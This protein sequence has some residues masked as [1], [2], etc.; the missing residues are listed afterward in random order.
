[1]PDVPYPSLA[2]FAATWSER[3]E[4]DEAPSWLHPAASPL[5]FVE[6]VRLKHELE[7]LI[8]TV[9]AVQRGDWLQD[10]VWV[11]P[12]AMGA[13]YRDL[14]ECSRT[15]GI[16]VPPAVVSGSAPSRQGVFGTDARAFLHLSSFFLA[17]AAPAERKFVIGR[18][19]GHVAAHQVTWVTS[20]ALLVDQGGLRQIA[21]RVLGPALEILLAPISFGANLALSHWHR[22]AEISADRAGLVCTGDLEGARRAMLRIA[23]G[24][25]PEMS[26]DEYLEQLRSVQDSASPAK[27][28]EI[29]SSQPWMHKRMLALELFASSA[30]WVELGGDPLP[31]RTLLSREA[32]AVETD[33]LLKVS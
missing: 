21:R 22:A 3:R 25:R 24:V 15:L 6:G 7:A 1:M 9:V 30:V 11:G 23:L 32:L 33:R 28:A 16:A 19:C 20:R 17:G 10:G 14:L 4:G 8:D 26:P 5:A 18:L 29:L 13:A 2:E 27:W 12:R 31:N